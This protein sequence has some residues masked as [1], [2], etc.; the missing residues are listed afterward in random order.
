MS[1]GESPPSWPCTTTSPGP[2]PTCP[3]R[4]ESACKSS[5]TRECPCPCSQAHVV[6]CHLCPCCGTPSPAWQDQ[7]SQG[8][9]LREMCQN[10][11]GHGE[12]RALTLEAVTCLLPHPPGPA[13]GHCGLT[14][15]SP[16]HILCSL[17]ILCPPTQS[18]IPTS[19]IPICAQLPFVCLDT[20][21]SFM[22]A[23]PCACTLSLVSASLLTLLSLPPCCR[24]GEKW[25]SGV[26]CTFLLLL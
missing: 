7:L 24:L 21:L 18:H 3:S 22:G 15:L 23:F 8:W 4:K 17:A 1:Q 19:P 25:M 20:S 2:K 10:A 12:T 16:S 5:T 26:Y 11:H 9:V 13:A 6:S 14:A